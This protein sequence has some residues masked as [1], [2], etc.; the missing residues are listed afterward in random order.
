MPYLA[1]DRK[2]IAIDAP[3]HGESD[4][5]PSETEA[6][7]PNYAKSAWSVL[8]ALKLDEVDLL[9]NHTGGLVAVEMACQRPRRIETIAMIS[10]PLFTDQELQHLRATLAPIPLDEDGT[11]M[12]EL[13]KRAIHFRGPG[14]SLE[15]LFANYA[16]Y[17]R[18]GDAYE[19]GHYAAFNYNCH[20][21]ERIQSIQNKVV[22]I[23]PGDLLFEPT[24]RVNALLNNGQIINY[25]QWGL[26]FLD[27]YPEDAADAINAAFN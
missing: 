27:A 21:A 3:G 18:A 14:V 10:A 7:I 8:D 1:E 25:P 17:F 24:L 16:E 5:P 23:N 9:G 19:W 6:S 11:R 12:S 13:W 4:L 20:F 15:D 22:I 26:G 2:V